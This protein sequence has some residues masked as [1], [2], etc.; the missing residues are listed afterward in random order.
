MYLGCSKRFPAHSPGMAIPLTLCF[1][2]LT[3]CSP[4]PEA[5]GGIGGTGLTGSVS[6]VSSGPLTKLG[7]VFVSGMKY[8]NSNAIYCIDDEPCST[9][10]S[11]KPGMVVLV[12]GTAQSSNQGAVTRVADTITFKETVEGVVQSVAQDGS[13]LIVLGQFIALNPKTV[14]DTSIPGR[15]I[16][17]LT[18]GLD[19]IEVS[20]LVASDGH[21]LAT[22]I[23]KR[24]GKP[25]YEV[26][27]IIKNHNAR[28][29]QFEIGQLMV[30]YSSADIS[31]I[32]TGG[33]T[34]WNG[35]L[36]H[37]RGD[38]WQPRSEV[39]YGARLTATRVTQL[40]LTV[41]DSAEAK[42]EGFI[43]QLTR[44]GRFAINNH[45]IEVSAD[46][47]FEGGTANELTLGAH[48]FIHA[49][50]VH[51]VLEAQEVAFKENVGIESNV[52]SVDIQSD[53][54]K[55][56]GLPGLSIARDALTVTE[57]E[58]IPSRF[59]D[60]RIG[61]HVRVHARLLDEQ[62]VVATE[63]ERTI[64]SASIV[65]QAPLQL[66]VDPRVLLAGTSIDTSRIP[67][68]EFVGPYGTIGRT[69]F[70]DKAVIGRPVWVKGTLAGSIVT[71]SSVGINR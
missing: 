63:L 18:P 19:A 40:G 53:T 45:P 32:A 10:N 5:G 3:S 12:K 69:A 15:S 46:T 61:D 30:E 48:V 35:R 71:W 38:E 23:M 28:D 67:D 64:P 56:A 9:E 27:G 22:L 58:G 4:S 11:L 41:E 7:S 21:I 47:K 8:D 50:L 2:A 59:E 54:L 43:T 55:L 29:Q 70:F 44:P 62:R 49:A 68:K 60:I 34:D 52:E 51:G 16:R 14:I 65:L 6:S 25:Q 36:V 57:H 37:V 1:L 31:D 13:S 66:A 17:N 33:T 24:T 42:I 39:P 20:G 26:Q